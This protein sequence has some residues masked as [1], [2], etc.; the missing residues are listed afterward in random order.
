MSNSDNNTI[1]LFS[2]FIM[3]ILTLV[4][5]GYVEYFFSKSEYLVS[6]GCCLGVLLFGYLTYGLYKINNDI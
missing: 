2:M 1:L 5:T 3:G 6:L 4:S